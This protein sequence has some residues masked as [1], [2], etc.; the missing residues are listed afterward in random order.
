VQHERSPIFVRLSDGGVRNA[1]TF[2]ILNKMREERSFSLTIQG[3]EGVKISVVGQEKVGGDAI[4]IAGPDSVA[5]YR[6][7]LTQSPE[8]LKSGDSKIAFVVTDLK[9]K[10][11]KSVDD[12]FKAP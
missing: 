1:Y 8:R 6:I 7:F 3:L 2:K 11:R 12:Y 9:S 4:L 5:E 10:M